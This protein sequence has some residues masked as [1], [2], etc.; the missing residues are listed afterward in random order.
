MPDP[1][2]LAE[3]LPC[4][5]PETAKRPDRPHPLANCPARLY[6]PAVRA[7][8]ATIEARAA[9]QVRRAVMDYCDLSADMASEGTT[10]QAQGLAVAYRDVAGKLRA[11]LADPEVTDA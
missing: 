8:V 9:A 2:P 10:P 3:A 7:Y 6:L 11:A 4:R 1:D 5:C